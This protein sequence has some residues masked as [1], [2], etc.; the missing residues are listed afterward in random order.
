MTL[1]DALEVL[2]KPNTFSVKILMIAIDKAVDVIEAAID[3]E[4]WDEE[5][6][7]DVPMCIHCSGNGCASCK[8]TGNAKIY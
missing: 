8:G 4:E 6:R 2:K 5:E 3:V 7:Y 1:S